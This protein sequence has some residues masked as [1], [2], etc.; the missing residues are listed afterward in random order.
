GNG[1]GAIVNA[2]DTALLEKNIGGLLIEST[3][4]LS[5]QLLQKIGE[6]S[7]D[8]QLVIN[9]DSFDIDDLKKVY[10]QTFEPL[11][12]TKEKQK[13]ELELDTQ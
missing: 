4:P 9:N 2:N 6:V 12:P 8:K 3:E 10:C 1:L 11:F 5:H 13:I 7:N